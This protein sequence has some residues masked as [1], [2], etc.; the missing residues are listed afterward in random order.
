MR[1]KGKQRLQCSRESKD[2]IL[3][4]LYGMSEYD[5]PQSFDETVILH[6]L[7]ALAVNGMRE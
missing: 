1:L 3:A 7:T 5:C 4:K 2:R 6:Q